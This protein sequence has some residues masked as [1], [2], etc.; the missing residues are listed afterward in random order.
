MGKGKNFYKLK[1]L[2]PI[3]MEMEGDDETHALEQVKAHVKRTLRRYDIHT[4]QPVYIEYI[5]PKE[6][7]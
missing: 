4:K 1:V 6:R 3:V 7:S 5:K 2:V